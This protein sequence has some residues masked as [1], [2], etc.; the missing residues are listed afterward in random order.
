MPAT[1]AP[2]TR[3]CTSAAARRKDSYLRWRTHPR[4]GQGHRRA[5]DPPG[6]RL[7]VSEN[8]E[9]AQACADAGLVF[10]GP[11]PS[12]IQAMGLKAEAKTLMEKAGVPL[13]P[14]YHG[15]DQDPALL[16]REAERIGYPVLIKASA[17]GGGKGMR[18]RRQGRGLRRRA[19]VVPARGHQQLRRRRGAGR[20]DTCTRP[21]HIEIQVFGDTHGNCVYLFERDCSVQRRHQ[22]VLEEAPAPGMTRG[23]AQRWATRR[24]RRRKAVGYVG[25]GTVEFIAEHARGRRALLL[26][27]DEHAAAGRAPG[28]RG[29]HRARPGR[30]AAARGGRRA[31]AAAAGGAARSTATRS[32][33]ASA[34]R[35]P[36]TASCRPPARCDVLPHCRAAPTGASERGRGAHRRRR[37]RG[38]RDHAVLRLDDRQ[39]DRLGRTRASRRWRGS[40][41]RWRRPHIVGLAHQRRVPAPRACARASFAQRRPRHRADRARARRAVRPAAAGPARGGRGRRRW[42]TRSPASARRRGADPWSAAAMA[43]GSHGGARAALRLRVRGGEHARGRAGAA[44]TTA[45]CGCSVGERRAAG[46]SRRALDGDRTTSRSASSRLHARRSYAHGEHGARVRAATARAD[47]ARVDRSRMPATAQP[48]AAA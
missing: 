7:P 27:G 39:A 26:H 8:E 38:R 2:A 40:T 15:A 35:T 24:W 1:C 29:D 33:R 22:K 13:V 25:A 11:P 14:G 23:A 28:D 45:R 34:P 30:V 21:R 32:R 9:F 48:R 16:Q 36:T 5:G 31:A 18:A 20:E 41:R 37:A 43:G 4:G 19:R 3:R 10:I 46:R 42:R 12:A 44:C 17:G 6:L 47:R